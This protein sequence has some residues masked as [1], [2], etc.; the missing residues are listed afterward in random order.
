[1]N[2]ETLKFLNKK[3]QIPW[4]P[5]EKA[6]LLHQLGLWGDSLPDKSVLIHT[7]ETKSLRRLINLY[8]ALTELP[9]NSTIIDIGSGNSLLDLVI[10]LVFPDKNFTFILV[11]EDETYIENETVNDKFYSADYQTY[12]NWSFVKKTIQLNNFAKDKFVMRNKSDVWSSSKV[13]L[14]MSSSSWGWH[15]PIETYLEKSSNLL[16]DGGYL[17]IDP[18]LNIDN[19]IDKV[20]NLCD[21]ILIDTQHPYTRAFSTSEDEKVNDLI[22]EGKITKEDFLFVFLGKK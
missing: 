5:F 8:P 19:S 4:T 9:I 20:R 21:V 14:I 22:N 1:M 18:I 17:Y 11:D 12:N 3:L 10:Q 13:D 15:Y 16:K 2:I 7:I 6:L